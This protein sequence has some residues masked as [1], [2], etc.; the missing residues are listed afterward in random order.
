MYARLIPGEDNSGKLVYEVRQKSRA[1]TLELSKE[2]LVI[3]CPPGIGY[4]LIASITAIN[5]LVVIIECSRAGFNDAKRL[6]E[7]AGNFIIPMTAVMNKSGLN[8]EIDAEIEK[9]LKEKNI[10]SAGNIPFN[11]EFVR[12]LN[13]KELLI[14]SEILSDSLR[15]IYAKVLEHIP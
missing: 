13:K 9:Y 10:K 11:E 3:D 7:V 2:F 15:R 12:I 6:I 1:V 4:P 14:D 5:F 8:P